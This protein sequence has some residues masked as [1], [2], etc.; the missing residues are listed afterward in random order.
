[1]CIQLA[2]SHVVHS[3]TFFVQVSVVQAYMLTLIGPAL[4][5][6]L[7]LYARPS[8]QLTAGAVLS[9]MYALIMTIVLVGTV[10]TAVLGSITS[11]NVLFL[12]TVI[13]IFFI[14][15][16]MHPMVMSSR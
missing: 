15:G 16:M 6:V 2:T 3:L 4:Y 11:P 8:V 13:F 5:L 12:F 14:S 10:G 9:A 1:M 7:C